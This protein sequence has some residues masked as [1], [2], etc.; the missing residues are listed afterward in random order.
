MKKIEFIGASGVGKSTLFNEL[1]KYRTRLEIWKTPSEARIK[2]AKKL[3][4]EIDK[5]SLN[6]LLLLCLKLNLIRSKHSS[7]ALCVLEK[8][9]TEK[10]YESMYKYNNLIDMMLRNTI[11]NSEVE[12]YRKGKRIEFYINLLLRDVLL[13]EGLS[14]NDLVVY[15]D[16]IIHNTSDFGDESSFYFMTQKNPNIITEILPQGVVFCELDAKEIY[17]RRKLRIYEGKG[18]ILESNLNDEDLKRICK[19]SI[20][21]SSK[22]V[23]LL[24]KYNVPVLKINMKVSTSKNIEMI[25]QFINKF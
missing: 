17:S 25:Q 12:P 22:K 16:G 21:S 20:E 4:L 11:N 14:D 2:L 13:L 3:P 9:R 10:I 18:T 8:Y 6:T 7:I 15:D 19:K 23:I 5:I 24:E 1:L